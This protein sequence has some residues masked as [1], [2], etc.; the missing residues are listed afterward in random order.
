[1]SKENDLISRGAVLK[2]IEDIKENPDTPKNYGTLL[3]IMREV[4]SIP[5]AYGTEKIIEYLKKYEKQPSPKRISD[6]N[7]R[8]DNY[9]ISTNSDGLM[10][11]CLDG[12]NII[13]DRYN[14]KSHTRQEAVSYAVGAIENYNERH[15]LAWGRLS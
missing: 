4:R 2:L 12:Q 1:M 5:A 11:I 3:D 9:Y 8:I 13:H 7:I 10:S 6:M 14:P 15:D